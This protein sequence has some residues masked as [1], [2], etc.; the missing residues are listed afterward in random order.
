MALPAFR[1]DLKGGCI[2]IKN[3]KCVNLRNKGQE[4]AWV[5][6]VKTFWFIDFLD[7]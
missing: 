7:A 6:N 3:A 2:L 1:K 5:G 4:A